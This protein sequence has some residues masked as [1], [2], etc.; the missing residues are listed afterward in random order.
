MAR[1]KRSPGGG[2]LHLP[3]PQRQT[4][5]LAPQFEH[6][7]QT[8]EERRARLQMEARD[9][10]PEEV[11]VLET[12][13]TVDEF[14]RA[15]EAVPGMEWLAEVE[16]EGIPPDDDFFALDNKGEERPGK[17][18]RGRVF[19]VFTNQAAL[20]QMVSLWKG[21]CPIGGFH[22]TWGDGKPSF[23][24]FVTFGIGGSR[25]DF[26]KRAYS[27]TGKSASSTARSWCHA[28]LSFGVG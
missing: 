1:R 15:V 2:K 27:K 17:T 6:L 22:E 3:S 16:A 19:M 14:I 9:L 5:R 26:R 8:L 10:V 13:G 28:K 23:N 24:S 4:E 18:F 25:I 20:Q 12:A 21:G 11:V 7:Q